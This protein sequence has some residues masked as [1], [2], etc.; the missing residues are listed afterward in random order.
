MDDETHRV[1]SA[2]L[3]LPVSMQGRSF[4]LFGGGASQLTLQ[5]G[6][7]VLVGPNG[8]GKTQALRAAHRHLVGQAGGC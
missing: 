5:G 7:T 6:L 8:A 1:P 4:P 2:L 3:P